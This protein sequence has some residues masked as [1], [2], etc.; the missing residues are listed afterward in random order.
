MEVTD[1]V[2][3]YRVLRNTFLDESSNSI[4][5]GLKHG[6]DDVSTEQ[7]VLEAVDKGYLDVVKGSDPRRYT[8]DFDRIVED[9]YDL[10]NE[11]GDVP[12]TPE[13]F[14][15]F[16]K[17][18]IRSYLENEKHS[19]LREM[20]M[21][22]FQIG[23]SHQNAQSYLSKDFRELHDRLSQNFEGKRSSGEH[24]KHGLDHR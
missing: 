8:V 13:N 4:Q 14:E 20:L 3:F 10:W 22:E 1:S 19:T 16:L 15:K 7:V 21:D 18:Y 2:V 17:S 5:L 6:M 12:A 11:V 23:L 9:W 24:I